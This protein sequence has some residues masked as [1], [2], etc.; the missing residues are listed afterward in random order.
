MKKIRLEDRNELCNLGYN[1]KKMNNYE[2]GNFYW[3]IN[4]DVLREVLIKCYV[5]VL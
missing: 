4:S 2:P 5:I 3:S 1:V